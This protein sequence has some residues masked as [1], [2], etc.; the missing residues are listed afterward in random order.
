MEGII[1]LPP[2]EQILSEIVAKNLSIEKGPLSIAGNRSFAS[3]N[4][5]INED[6]VVAIFSPVM[7]DK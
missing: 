6:I 3:A 4:T 5:K 2:Y 1:G 7:E